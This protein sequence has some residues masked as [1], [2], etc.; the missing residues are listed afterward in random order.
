PP[1][2]HSFPPR[3][4][5]D[6]TRVGL[7]GQSTSP[8]ARQRCAGISNQLHFRVPES[9]RRARV[10]RPSALGDPVQRASIICLILGAAVFGPRPP[11]SEEHTS[12]L[13]SREN[14]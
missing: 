13:Q 6:L 14:L 5:S 8:A 4:S 10:R 9:Q 11:R 3:R 2:L 7:A 12:E 1:A